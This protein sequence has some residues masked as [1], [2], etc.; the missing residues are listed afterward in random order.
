MGKGMMDGT[1]RRGQGV[2]R[3]TEGE[4][5]RGGKGRERMEGRGATVAGEANGGDEGNV[6]NIDEDVGDDVDGICDDI[7][8]GVDDN[9]DDC[10]IGDDV[11]GIDDVSDI[12]DDADDCD[13]GDD[14]DIEGDV[15]DIGYDYVGDGAVGDSDG[16]DKD[17]ESL[18]DVDGDRRGKGNEDD[19]V[20]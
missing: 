17:C 11:D 5:R 14:C 15:D 3:C 10:D 20:A 4:T 19:E 16:A 12:G 13:I 7:G 18:G 6:G 9:G 8:D 1:R 2:A